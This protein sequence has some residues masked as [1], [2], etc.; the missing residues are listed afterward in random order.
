MPKIETPSHGS[1]CW[2]ELATS[3]LASAKQ[4]YSEMF[5]WTVV[6]QPG[7]DG[8]YVIFQSGGNDAA[9]MYS[10]PAGTPARWGVYFATPNVDE[11]A[12]KIASLGG[13]IVAGPFDVMEAGRMA[14]AQDPQGAA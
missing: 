1:F 8:V 10:A 14:V 11:S 6:E 13:K 2:A 7:P 12:A 9:A 5:D 4:F 3:D